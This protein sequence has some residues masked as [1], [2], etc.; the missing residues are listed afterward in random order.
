MQS[1]TETHSSSEMVSTGLSL[2]PWMSEATLPGFPTAVA[3][4]LLTD[5]FRIA[6]IQI[7]A[8]SPPL[9]ATCFKEVPIPCVTRA[10]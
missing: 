8:E 10:D 6:A 7:F 2:L 4:R 3:V 1:V 5:T 9:T